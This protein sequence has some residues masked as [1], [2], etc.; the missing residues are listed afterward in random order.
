MGRVRALAVGNEAVGIDERRALFALAHM[1][2]G[3]ER[4]AEGGPALCVEAALD[5]GDQRISTLTL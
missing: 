3:L 2:G 1:A 4:L 5:A